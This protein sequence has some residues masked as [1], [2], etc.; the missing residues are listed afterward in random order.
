MQ[1][2]AEEFNTLRSIA[3]DLLSS[4]DV[5]HALRVIVR[6]A[7]ERTHAR[8][9]HIYLYDQAQERLTFGASL[10]A[11]GEIDKEINPPRPNGLT[12]AVAHSGE[13]IVISNVRE[14]PL[15]TEA[16]TSLW[17]REPIHEM[18]ALVGVPLKRGDEVIG[19]FNIAFDEPNALTEDILRYLDFLAA[20]A[21]VAIANAKLQ[22]ETR[23]GRDLLQAILDS[24]HDGIIML[25]MNE[26]LVMVNSRMEWLLN[27]HLSEYI[28]M[29]MRAVLR[30]LVSSAGRGGPFLNREAHTV[31]RQIQQNPNQITRRRYTLID[32]SLRAIE[33]VSLPVIGHNNEL[34]GRMF[35]LRDI[36]QEYELETYRQEMSHMLIHDLRSPL[37]GVITGLHTAMDE[38]QLGIDGEI[39]PDLPMVNSMLSVALSSAGALLKLVESI[40]DIHKLETGEVPLNL[41]EVDLGLLADRAKFT[42]EG[43]ARDA[44]I[45]IAI[46]R[47]HDLPRL[48]A[49]ADKIERVFINLLDNALR[50]TP[51][52]GSVWISVDCGD[53]YQTVTL[54]DTGEGVPSDMRDRIF[55]RFVQADTTRRKRGSKGSGL[56][57]T[58]C[59]LAVEA[60][61]GRIWVDQGPEG[62]AAFHF[63]LPMGL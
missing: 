52:G 56:G 48:K 11:D 10:W 38:L 22:E 39:T 40:L 23:T 6:G 61:G 20:E 58:F 43:T 14:H 55:E 31:L 41:D 34:L 15:F 63:T 26:R 29:P 33:E 35:I 45:T 50:Y 3:V 37:G 5:K 13:R 28:G 60:H 53:T 49:D 2:R 25:D 47:P 51:Q 4:T 44:A 42:L 8:D 32:P 30:Q 59:R 7:M 18:G 24:S 46:E 36:T 21:S 62:G 1:R 12:M 9:V 57:L 19:V 16:A 17:P 27:V 54:R